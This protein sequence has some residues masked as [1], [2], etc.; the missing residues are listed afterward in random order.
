MMTSFLLALAIL[1]GWPR[2][3]PANNKPTIDKALTY[4]G[5]IYDPYFVLE[6]NRDCSEA[7]LKEVYRKL[8]FLYHEDR[9]VGR[10]KLE[11]ELAREKQKKISYYYNLLKD[12]K[13]EVDEFLKKYAPNPTHQQKPEKKAPEPDD[14]LPKT[15]EPLS[16]KA[17]AAMKAYHHTQCNFAYGQLFNEYL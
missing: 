1:S 2:S 7:K 3:A 5:K 8:M 12:R 9:L 10:S 11:I 15:A 6:V 17:K 4:K 14:S 13:N 16:A